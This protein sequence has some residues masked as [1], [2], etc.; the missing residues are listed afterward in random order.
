M[1]RPLCIIQILLLAFLANESASSNTHLHRYMLSGYKAQH[2]PR[3]QMDYK[4]RRTVK[5]EEQVEPA[6]NNDTAQ[7]GHSKEPI[8]TLTNSGRKVPLHE[9]MVRIYQQNK[10]MCMGTMISE[11]L[12]ITTSTCFED[13]LLDVV[14]MKT[15]DDE[16]LEG[17]KVPFNQTYLKG[18]DPMLV[19]IQLTKSPKN[20][21][22]TGDT[23]KLCDS[24]LEVYEPIEMPLWIRS[25]HSIH[26]QTT[27]TI[28]VQACRLRMRDP[29]AVV[30]TDTMICVK[31]FKYTR[32]CQMAIG[33]PLVHDERICGINV[34]G[35]NCPAFTGAD[36]YI[37][38]YDALAFSML[39]MEIIRD[40]RIEDTI[41]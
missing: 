21:Q 16:G 37:R 13:D 33:N 8:V 17:K 39:G 40:S 11:M 36:L 7:I 1:L 3:T 34:A 38:V 41:F 5:K 6:P 29:D 27:Y 35:H 20:S 2:N 26:S 24:E 9:L 22:V 31:N 10:Y 18:A 14:T 25:R 19:I 28:P 15:Y 23:V 30:V 32:K 4:R 12:V